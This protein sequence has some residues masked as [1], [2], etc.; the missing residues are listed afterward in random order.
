MTRPLFIK[1]P[2]ERA[3][4]YDEQSQ[5]FTMRRIPAPPEVLLDGF[6]AGV[7]SGEP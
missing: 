6:D 2:W 3:G 4:D 5:S 7:W 1:T